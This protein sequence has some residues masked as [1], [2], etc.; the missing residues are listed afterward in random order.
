MQD[1]ILGKVQE[2]AELLGLDRGRV[3][4]QSLKDNITLPRPRIEL[5]FLPET[6]QRTGRL[7]G[8]KHTGP[9][10]MAV[11]KELYQV[12]LPIA[13]QI[14]ADDPEWLKE[15]CYRLAAALPRGFNDAAGNY[16]KLVSAQG[17]WENQAVRRVG[18]AVIEPIV[19]RGYL[20]H[21]T[22]T[23]RITA[24]ELV[25]LVHKVDFKIGGLQ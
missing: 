2:A 14:L 6:Y 3:M 19:K 1:L 15:F 13:A 25:N 21:L 20:L 22:A 11:R 10:E 23:W 9:A 12:S 16:V 18:S 7:L 5:Q 4:T 17:A 24:E 8:G